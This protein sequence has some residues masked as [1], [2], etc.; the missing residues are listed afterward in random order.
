MIQTYNTSLL[1]LIL[2]KPT[3]HPVYLRGQRLLRDQGRTWIRLWLGIVLIAVGIITGA[4]LMLKGGRGLYI[5]L[6][7]VWAGPFILLLWYAP[8]KNY[9]WE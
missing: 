1:Y 4:M 3:F 6:I 7:V 8:M 2:S 9:F 5:G